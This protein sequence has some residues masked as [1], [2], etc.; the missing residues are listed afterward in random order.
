MPLPQPGPTEP[1]PNTMAILSFSR[2]VIAGP[3]L[4]RATRRRSRSRASGSDPAPRCALLAPPC[5]AG[6]ILLLACS[7]RRAWFWFSGGLISSAASVVSQI[8][9]RSCEDSS[10]RGEVARRPMAP[11]RLPL[12]GLRAFETASRLR[13][14]SA[15][16]TELGVTHGAVSRHVRGLEA[17]FG[18][19]LLRRLPKSVE[20]T[21]SGAQLAATLGEAFEPHPPRRVAPDAGSADAVLLG[22]DHDVLADPAARPVQARPSRDRASPQ[23]QL[24]GGGLRQ[25]RD[26]PRHPVQH[27]PGAP[28]RRDPA[29]AARGHRPDLPS[30]LRPKA[31]PACARRPRPGAH[32]RHGD[33]ASG[34]GRMAPGD[35]PA[36]SRSRRPRA[37][38]S[39]ST[40]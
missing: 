38:S 23:R 19:P 4:A 30:R 10:Q 24:R 9:A 3:V 22:D 17:E 8:D 27:G 28:G 6:A 35:R 37:L 40:S 5:R 2:S 33:S 16:A 39:I 15:A 31:R 32:S 1:A 18:V 20:P 26:Q 11:P 25:G 21:P 36:R 29:A 14:M 12:N 13:S 34:L 7:T